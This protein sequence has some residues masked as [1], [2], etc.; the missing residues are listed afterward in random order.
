MKGMN[1]MNVFPAFYV[2][3][4]RDV[5]NEDI[6][7]AIEGL[8]KDG[9]GIVMEAS[10]QWVVAGTGSVRIVVPEEAVAWYGACGLLKGGWPS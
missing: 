3:V 8:S 6:V 10:G 7:A 2:S 1:G 9:T 5:P 4:E